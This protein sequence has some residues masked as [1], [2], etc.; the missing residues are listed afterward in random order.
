LNDDAETEALLKSKFDTAAEKLKQVQLR[1][2]T[3]LTH[4]DD[5]LVQHQAILLSSEKELVSQD[6]KTIRALLRHEIRV[7]Y[8]AEIERPLKQIFSGQDLEPVRNR[9]DELHLQVL[10]SRL[11]VALHM[12]AGDGNVHTNIPVN[13]NDYAMMHEA[14]R[15]VD[16]IMELATSLGGVISGEHGIGITKFQYL[17][18]KTI[19]AFTEYKNKVDPGHTFNRGKLLHDTGGLERAYTPSLRLLKQ[20]AIAVIK[21]IKTGSYYPGRK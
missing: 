6:S 4:L 5:E 11:F 7:S 21:I 14:E 1:W 18:K 17:E 9:L 13:S 2:Q 12:H 15:V 20:E 3:L 16:R 8:R 10:S 19:D